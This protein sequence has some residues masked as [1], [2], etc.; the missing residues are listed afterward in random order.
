MAARG[1][2]SVTT[3]ERLLAICGRKHEHQMV[4][5]DNKCETAFFL[6]Q[7]SNGHACPTAIAEPESEEKIHKQ[8]A[9]SHRYRLMIIILSLRFL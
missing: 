7:Q 2:E 5:Q 1:T 8:N 4:V 9:N 6:K 3:D